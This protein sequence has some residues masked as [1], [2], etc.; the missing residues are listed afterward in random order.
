MS[1]RDLIL[2]HLREVQPASRALPE[3]PLFDQNLPPAIEAFKNSLARLGGTWCEPPHDG[4]VDNFIRGR[5]PDALVV[6]SAVPEVKGTRRIE[7]VARPHDL[8]DV[9]VGVVRPAFAVAETG[10]I[11]LSEV[12]YQVNALGY[13]SQ[14]LVVLLDPQDIV[15]NLH[16]AYHRREFFDARYAVLMSGPSA[17]ADIEGVLIRGAQGIRSLTVLPMP[18]SGFAR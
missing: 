13:L 2:S 17:T 8:Q 16:H 4:D 11:W 10:S 18:R 6:C 15:G 9:D 3:V 5:F 1:S 7:E 14:H 12:E